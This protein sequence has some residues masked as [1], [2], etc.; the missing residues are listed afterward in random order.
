[1]LKL[2]LWTSILL[3]EIIWLLSSIPYWIT[4]NAR[5]GP[6]FII[7]GASKGGTSSLYNSISKHPQV[8]VAR[9]K[10]PRFFSRYYRLGLNYYRSYFPKKNE[11]KV[12]GE[13]TTSYFYHEQVPG[14]IKKTF[15]WSKTDSIAKR[16][17]I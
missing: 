8:K 13:A 7:I 17:S 4:S 6:D 10:E 1:M 14:R 3:W 16:S 5:S 9:M 12:T 15:F 11:N 2:K